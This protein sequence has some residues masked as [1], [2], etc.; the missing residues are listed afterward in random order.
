MIKDVQDFIVQLQKI[1]SQVNHLAKQHSI[2]E[3]SIAATQLQT[4]ELF[5]GT[6]VGTP[7]TSTHIPEDNTKQLETVDATG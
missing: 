2:R 1:R 6:V 3:F 5:L 4:A 7:E